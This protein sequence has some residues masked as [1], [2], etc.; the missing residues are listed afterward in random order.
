VCP[1]IIAIWVSPI[2]FKTKSFSFSL[3]CASRR[4]VLR[5]DYTMS[6]AL[7]P[8]SWSPPM[9]V[10]AERIHVERKIAHYLSGISRLLIWLA[11]FFD[12]SFFWDGQLATSQYGK[13]SWTDPG[14]ICFPGCL[15]ERCSPSAVLYMHSDFAFCSRHE[16]LEVGDLLQIAFILCSSRA[17]DVEH[18]TLCRIRGGSGT[19]GTKLDRSLM[20]RLWLNLIREDGLIQSQRI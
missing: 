10:R 11:Y 20:A 2:C 8:L 6:D 17:S 1:R 19:G 18:F 3:N 14:F 5:N 9:I 4:A 12:S 13:A 16:G 7:C 15:S